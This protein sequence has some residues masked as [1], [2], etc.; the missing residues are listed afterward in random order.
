LP[1]A[2][3]SMTPDI[4]GHTRK[5]CVMTIKA[6]RRLLVKRAALLDR[7]A[8]IDARLAGGGVGGAQSPPLLTRLILI[9]AGENRPLTLVEFLVLVRQGGFTTEA[10]DFS[11]MIW[12]AIRKLVDRGVLVRGPDAGQYRLAD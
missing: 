2:D 8:E 6:V 11:H 10:K 3:N 5:E 7:V 4:A 12:M 9:A 1:H